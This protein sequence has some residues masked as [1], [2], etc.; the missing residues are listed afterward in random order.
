MMV[1]VDY[2]NQ[3]AD[4]DKSN[5]LAVFPVVVSVD[6]ATGNSNLVFTSHSSIY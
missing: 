6:N 2:M 3:C 5:N 4:N 1:A